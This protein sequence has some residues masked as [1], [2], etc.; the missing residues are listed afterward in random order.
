MSSKKKLF[1]YNKYYP[2]FFI[3]LMLHLYQKIGTNNLQQEGNFNFLYVTTM[4]YKKT[5]EAKEGIKTFMK[6][7]CA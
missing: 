3:H 4:K 6:I 5:K 2:M 7:I 1:D